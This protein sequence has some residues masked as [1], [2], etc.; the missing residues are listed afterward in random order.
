MKKRPSVIRTRS[1]GSL[2]PWL[3]FISPGIVLNKDGSLLA[4]YRF[5]G[6][7]AESSD[8]GVIDDASRALDHALRL[9]DDGRYTLWWTVVRRRSRAYPEGS[10]TRPAAGRIE[11]LHKR[12]FE[13]GDLF[14][15]AHYL[16]ILYTPDEGVDRF[17]DRVAYHASEGGKSWPAALFESARDAFS[18]RRA[19]A[20]Q[21]AQLD[22]AQR[23]MEAAL[24]Q[25]S[26]SLSM[27]GLRRLELADFFGFLNALSS[28]ASAMFQPRLPRGGS[29]DGQTGSDRISVGSDSIEFKGTDGVRYA[30]AVTVRGWPVATYPG[31]L[32]GLVTL[33]AETNVSVMLRLL[34][35]ER[36]RNVIKSMAR[37]YEFTQVSLLGRIAEAVLKTNARVDK[38]KLELLADAQAALAASTAEGAMFAYANLTAVVFGR[39]NEEME[40]AAKDAI[41][42]V[43]RAGFIAL[44]EGVNL[45]SAWASTLPGQWHENPRK[46]LVS[47]ACLSDLAPL[48]TLDAGDIVN[49]HL[50]EQSGRTQPA[51][52]AFATRSRQ[53]YYLNL[54]NGDVAHTIV[55]GPSGAGKSVFV[56]FLIS[57]YQKYDPVTVIFDKNRSCMIPTIMQGGAHVD[58]ASEN[59]PLN[60]LRLLAR[61]ECWPFLLRWLG[62]LLTARGRVLSAEDEKVAWEAL[63]SLAALP[64]ERW[65]LSNLAALLSGALAAELRAWTKGGG[66][67]DMFDNQE[68]AF[69]LGD[70]TCVEM[71]DILK[72]GPAARAFM[73]YAFQVVDMAL[74]GRRPALIYVEEAWFMLS[75]ETFCARI[76]DWLRTLRKKNAAVIL[77]TQSL[78]ELRE[79]KIF[80]SIVDNMPNRIFLANR[81]APA[82]EDIYRDKFGLTSAQV[83]L[84]ASMTPKLEYYLVNR[85]HARMLSV[86]MP[87]EILAYLRSD[88]RAM[89]IFERCRKSGAPDWRQRYLDM[90]RQE[91]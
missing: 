69:E 90:M 28:P 60:P 48:R 82:H 86:P 51:L 59:I 55:V 16:S 29:L 22:Q 7:D 30:A 78:A 45:L 91:N 17:F 58:V 79:A 70:F 52:A 38:G 66:Q 19:F 2:L 33:P 44:R 4:C 75:D 42:A 56:N 88:G 14:E 67:W 3:C 62:I 1:L 87:G 54:H 84:I 83:R 27:L 68:D 26:G 40:Q 35:Q 34:D 32:D 8:P 23:R 77:A 50:T 21:Q 11:A 18:R 39:S 80:A 73:E 10:F 9:L 6:V 63:E 64:M 46:Q 47:A 20:F 85:R 57:Q 13:S 81:D 65:T 71:G 24:D 5:S 36:A 49:A 15:N 43:N 76:D 53:P 31:A 37:Y 25:F 61:R 89:E 12:R 72:Q 41:S 74:D